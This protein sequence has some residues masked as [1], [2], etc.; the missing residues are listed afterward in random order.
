MQLSFDEKFPFILSLWQ[1]DS[2]IKDHM[3]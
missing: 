1:G 2:C 3:H